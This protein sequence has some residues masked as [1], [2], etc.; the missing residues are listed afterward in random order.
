MAIPS[1]FEAFGIGV[2]VG[3]L[4]LVSLLSIYSIWMMCVKQRFVRLNVFS[5]LRA[6]E[7][8]GEKTYENMVEATLPRMGRGITALFVLL[9][10]FGA[11]SGFLVSLP[12]TFPLEFSWLE[13]GRVVCFV[14]GAFLRHKN[15]WTLPSPPNS[16]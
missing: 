2:G 10:V 12:R 7:A 14:Q 15:R 3:S 16:P 6:S 5:R 1:T 8:S 11:L 9:L 13:S 4:F